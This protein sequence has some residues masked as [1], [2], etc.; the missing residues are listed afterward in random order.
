[1]RI[2]TEGE[3]FNQCSQ[4]LG[5]SV[6]SVI[7]SDGGDTSGNESLAQCSDSNGKPVREK[8][9]DLK[10]LDFQDLKHLGQEVEKQAR[11]EAKTDPAT[12]EHKSAGDQP[13]WEQILDKI[14]E[15]LRQVAAICMRRLR[16]ERLPK[17][18]VP[19]LITPVKKLERE[20]CV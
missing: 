9:V 19:I 4:V 12:Q 1:M 17:N 2:P 3:E 14:R 8:R 6:P 7:L 20:L 5:S 16:R 10:N 13:L 18:V 11:E 15:L